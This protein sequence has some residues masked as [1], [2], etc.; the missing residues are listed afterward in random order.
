MAIYEKLQ[1][2]KRES[3]I[4]L[5]NAILSPSPNLETPRFAFLLG[6]GCSLS[7]G[8]PLASSL[9][10]V[11]KK[12]TFTEYHYSLNKLVRKDKEGLDSFMGRVDKYIAKYKDQFD[13]FVLAENASFKR[14]IKSDP[15]FTKGYLPH[16]TPRSAKAYFEERYLEDT[17]YGFWFENYSRS[18]RDRQALIEEVIS[19]IE[20]GG[21]YILFS[22]LIKS[23][24][25]RNV[26]T[27]NFDDLLNEALLFYFGIKP[28]VYSHNEVAQYIRYNSVT[29]NII[30]LHGDY[31]FEN[32]KNLRNETRSLSENMRRKFSEALTMQDLVVIGYSGADESIMNV[33][34]QIQEESKFSLYWC[35]LSEKEL[36]WRVK[37]LINE[38][39]SAFFVQIKDFD[40]FV[41]EL[42]SATREEVS[43]KLRDQATRKEKSMREYLQ[44]FYEKRFKRS[45][46]ICP[47][48]PQPIGD[49]EEGKELIPIL[50]ANIASPEKISKYYQFLCNLNPGQAWI[51]NNYV[52]HLLRKNEHVLA[53]EIARQAISNNPNSS[54]LYYN[55]GV[56]Y[57]DANNLEEAKKCFLKCIEIDN[58][59]DEAYNNLA[60]TMNS[61]REYPQAISFIDKALQISRKGKYLVNKAVFL[62]NEKRYKEAL[63]LY[64]EAIELDEELARA[65]Y[66]KSNL[67]R[68][69]EKYDQAE[70]LSK[71]ALEIDPENEYIY[72][73]LAEICAKQGRRDEFYAYL[74][75][76]LKRNYPVWRHLDEPAFRPYKPDA[77]FKE[78]VQN[79]TPINQHTP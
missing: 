13:E 38:S 72:A 52:V 32:I 21:V 39:P 28:K 66:N 15:S 70:I 30:K 79:Y 2:G 9:I 49:A 74:E 41:F 20:P 54:L 36:H 44:L 37:K 75:E 34:S 71:R 68:L 77:L 73:T 45:H 35:D 78:L 26:F 7:S 69:M 31:Q 1:A 47:E 12:L 64:D 62:K 76:A 5:I 14:R 40:D 16:K 57:H 3:P 25:I 43:I 56:I 51:W 42:F 23:G 8:I 63:L 11:F 10:E 24:Y 65:L 50:E 17:R 19:D 29:P 27:T 61:Q 58:N 4:R 18:S 22:Q 48:L 60:A 53:I 33:L 55:L 67:L 46:K 59:F 6:A